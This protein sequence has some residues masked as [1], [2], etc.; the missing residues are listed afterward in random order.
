MRIPQPARR[1][2]VAIPYSIELV[3]THPHT[4]TQNEREKADVILKNK[5]YKSERK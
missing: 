1:V 3:R 4:H 2:V 5:D